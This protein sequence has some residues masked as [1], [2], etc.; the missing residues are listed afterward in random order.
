MITRNALTLVE[1]V[2][3]L[4]VLA[5]LSGLL[6]PLFSGT[7]QSAN[8]RTTTQS[9]VATRD[10][11]A[12]YWRD[13]KHIPLDGV[14]TVATEAN[15]LHVEWLFHN[16]VTG[17]ATWDYSPNTR[18]GWRG[19]YIT[20]PTAFPTGGGTPFLIDAWNKAI[21][22]QDVD[23]TA[24]VRDVRVVSGGPNG[25][26][27]TLGSIATDSLTAADTGDDVYVAVTLR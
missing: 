5:A 3:V 9:L 6:L 18:I 17:D 24:A 22:I 19:P 4:S 14:L 12:E 7:I 21:V 11:L 15:R 23:L 13:T 25:T 27:D 20:T 2:V 16:P 26:V 1:L 8:E 10:A